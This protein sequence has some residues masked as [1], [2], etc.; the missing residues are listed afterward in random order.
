MMC[1]WWVY[2]LIWQKE[3]KSFSFTRIKILQFVFFSTEINDW[4][5]KNENILLFSKYL[6]KTLSFPTRNKIW[7]VVYI[8]RTSDIDMCRM[9]C[10]WDCRKN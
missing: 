1:S 7:F 9:Y 4:H 10:I 2:K 8:E 6:Q 3:K 5:G